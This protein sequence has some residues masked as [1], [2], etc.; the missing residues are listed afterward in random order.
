MLSRILI[1][2]LFNFLVHAVMTSC[3]R[4]V[5][6]SGSEL[7]GKCS[8]PSQCLEDTHEQGEISD[9]VNLHLRYDKVVLSYFV[10]VLNP[11]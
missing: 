6:C 10:E 4:A 9:V 8:R 1:T 2:V 7:K 5:V 3:T 11:Y